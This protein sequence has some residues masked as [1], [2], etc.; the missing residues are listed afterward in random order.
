M[1]MEDTVSR[2]ADL[3]PEHERLETGEMNGSSTSCVSRKI[4][5]HKGIRST[6]REYPGHYASSMEY[7]VAHAGPR[8]G[9]EKPV[10]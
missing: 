6:F 2:A 7:S 5:H 9:N 1:M 3:K 10:G 4:T 8:S